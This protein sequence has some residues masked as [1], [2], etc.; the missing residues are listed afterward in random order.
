MFRVGSFDDR[1]AEVFLQPFELSVCQEGEL[2]VR[3]R[4]LLYLSSIIC[5]RSRILTN[6][7]NI[8]I[9][10]RKYRYFAGEM[11]FFYGYQYHP[12]TITKKDRGIKPLSFALA[13]KGGFE[14]PVQF[15]VRQFSKLLV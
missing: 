6:E 7:T 10:I 4:I 1:E 13:E 11:T 15:P 5:V 12:F 2:L 8:K 14:P 9:A 3:I